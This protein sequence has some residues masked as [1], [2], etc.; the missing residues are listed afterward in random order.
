M[1]HYILQIY[2]INVHDLLLFCHVFQ[3]PYNL[4][5]IRHE[6]CED[7]ETGADPQDYDIVNKSTHKAF[8]QGNVTLPFDYDDNLQVRQSKLKFL[9]NII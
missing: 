4:K 8:L 7:Q 2:T 5:L 6:L 3:G 1:P 9:V